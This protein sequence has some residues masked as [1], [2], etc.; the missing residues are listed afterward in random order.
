[1]LHE[2]KTWKVLGVEVLGINMPKTAIVR[3]KDEAIDVGVNEFGN[4]VGFF[5]G[6]WGGGYAVDKVLKNL[7]IPLNPNPA[8]LNQGRVMKSFALVPPL[9]AFMVAM[10][11]LRNAFTTWRTG[12]L[13]YKDLITTS[14][15]AAQH[16]RQ[17]DKAQKAIQDYV[18]KGVNI[19]LTGLGIGAAGFL[20]ARGGGTLQLFRPNSSKLI[21]DL[22][23][24]WFAK[25]LRA[26]CLTGEKATEYGDLR[27]MFYWGIPTYLAWMAASRDKF[28]IKEQ[29]LKMV[30]FV[31]VYVLT[32]KV[33]ARF[34]DKK[35]HDYASKLPQVYQK[36]GGGFK[37][38]YDAMDKLLK[39]TTKSKLLPE[40]LKFEQTKL[41]SGFGL[42]IVLMAALP[43]MLNIYLTNRRM[44]RSQNETSPSFFQTSSPL[45]LRPLKNPLENMSASGYANV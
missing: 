17:K 44:A 41:L 37:F 36:A 22:N 2:N 42:T 18:R 14:D 38:S 10:P 45:A 40:I 1:M 30:N 8:I 7:H 33:V 19:L 20:V 15:T 16:A 26:L 27:A 25:T 5:G 24:P 34:F 21:P 4:T 13:D 43:A 12:T 32:D 3:T 6:V 9:L 29:F 23:K 28:E 11:F 35:T 31:A 39:R